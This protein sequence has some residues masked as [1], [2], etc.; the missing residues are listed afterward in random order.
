MITPYLVQ[1]D[2]WYSEPLTLEAWVGDEIAL[3]IPI[4]ADVD[5]TVM[6]A[7]VA[8]I[9]DGYR[10]YFS[11][12]GREPEYTPQ[13]TL[14]GR[15][16]IA[17]VEELGGGA[18]RAYLGVGGIEILVDYFGANLSGPLD[19]VRGLYD[20]MAEDGS[21]TSIVFYELG[22]NFWFYGQQLGDYYNIGYWG[23]DGFVSQDYGFTTAYAVINR[24]F[25]MLNTDYDIDDVSIDTVQIDL[26]Q[27][28]L[29]PKIAETYFADTSVTAFNT[30]ALYKGIV[31]ETFYNSVADLGAALLRV[32]HEHAGADL[33]AR[34]WQTLPEVGNLGYLSAEASY[35]NFMYN[36]ERVTNFDYSFLFKEG[37]TFTVGNGSDDYLISRAHSGTSHAVLGFGGNDRLVGSAGSET[38]LGD[39]GNDFLAG[40]AGIDQLAGGTGNDR[41]EGGEGSDRL[42]GGEGYDVAIY[43]SIQSNYQ[44]S[45]SQSGLLEI[46]DI[47]NNS[48]EGTDVVSNVEAI[49]FLDGTYHVLTSEN[50][51]SLVLDDFDSDIYTS[52]TLPI[53]VTLNGSL[54]VPLDTDWFAVSV[55]AG[56]T[57]KFT[58]TPGTL[59]D[60]SISLWGSNGEYISTSD[61]FRFGPEAITWT[62]TYTGDA[63]IVAGS[64]NSSEVG[65]YL[66]SFAATFTEGR[67]VWTGTATGEIIDALGGNDVLD[68]AGG[69]DRIEGGAGNDLLQGGDG[70]DTLI[71][72]IGNDTLDGG[73]GPDTASY[74]TSYAAV[75]ANLSISTA[76]NTGPSGTDTFVSIENL[77]G[78]SFNDNLIGSAAANRIEGGGG[79]DTLAGGWGADTLNAGAGDDIF[80]IASWSDHVAGELIEGGDGYDE[81]LV[82][83]TSSGTLILQPGT[84]VE[85]VVIGTGVAITPNT[86]GTTVIGVDGSGL[87]SDITI[88]GNNGS[89]RLSGGIANDILFG[90][91]GHDTLVG[92]AGNDVLAGGVGRD[93][94]SGG[95]GDDQFV[96]DTRPNKKKNVDTITDFVIGEDSIVLENSIFTA[97][98]TTIGD[99]TAASFHTGAKAAAADDRIIYNPTNGA[100][101]YDTNGSAKGGAVQIAVLQTGLDL[102]H[103]DFYIL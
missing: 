47:R 41:L 60:P 91:G 74:Q 78:S 39:T 97:L 103:H 35:A 95:E 68:G 42:D 75:N 44:L 66:I 13:Q 101:I 56:T 36:A 22:R 17:A 89:S 3:L 7:I 26:Y 31:N 98:G 82:T 81:I 8:A 93:H 84:D 1:Y 58:M 28:T 102:S 45:F 12:T 63:F 21:L 38:L 43:N 70:N 4:E 61:D 20:S 40:L 5:P 33:Y 14:D 100:L 9:D 50:G 53:G 16:I 80:V 67:D 77:I 30:L 23:D 2:P 37:W 24:Y 59:A 51:A 19:W 79:S 15:I 65:S 52:N 49:K 87:T 92:G 54:E 32:F 57:Y 62:A 88:Y 99:L 85:R 29:L 90:N 11:I 69:D 48:P 6:T 46:N 73:A 10:Y 34:F 86:T 94:L 72:G 71:G 55:T 27:N 25:A 64:H 83:M 76:Q 96:F 18:G